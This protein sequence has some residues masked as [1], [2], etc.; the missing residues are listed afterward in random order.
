M[1]NASA[2]RGVCIDLARRNASYKRAGGAGVK[3]YVEGSKNLEW[4]LKW[5]QILTGKPEEITLAI[6]S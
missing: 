6:A 5:Q 2:W 1:L 4:E 3:Q